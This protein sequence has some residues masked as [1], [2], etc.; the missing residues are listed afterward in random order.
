MEVLWEHVEVT[1]SERL[2]RQFSDRGQAED[3]VA[4]LHDAGFRDDEVSLSTRGGRTL[5]DGTFAPG[6][7]VLIVT[8]DALR[9]REAE[10]II[11]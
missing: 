9:A 4:R 1:Q 10:R 6:G 11:S 8:A 5:A 3:A 2:Q 7:L